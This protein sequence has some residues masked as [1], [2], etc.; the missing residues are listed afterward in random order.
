MSDFS[1]KAISFERFKQV[2]SEFF[3][4]RFHANDIENIWHSI[5]GK[6]S[7]DGN[8]FKRLFGD[9]WSSSENDINFEFPKDSWKYQDFSIIKGTTI[10]ST[11]H[12]YE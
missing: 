1:N 10:R 7:L 3:G 8:Q 5:G 11:E 12:K 6:D 4:N 2:V 9:A